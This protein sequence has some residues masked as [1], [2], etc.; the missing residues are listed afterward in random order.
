MIATVPG[1]VWRGA[2]ALLPAARQPGRLAE[3]AVKVA[4]LCREAD[5]NGIYRRLHSHWPN[6]DAIVIGGSEGRNVTWDAS[7]AAEL[8]DF[9]ERMQFF[10]TVTYLP[11]DILTKVDRA[12]MAVSLE[13]RVPM[14]DHRVVEAAWSLP[15]QLRRRGGVSKW[16]LRSI[17]ARHVP[18][19]L[20]DRPKKGFAVPL[21]A[22]LRGPLRE[23]AG[24]LLAADR[25][26]RQGYLEPAPIQRLWQDF[27]AGRPTFH[28]PLWGVLMFQSWLECYDGKR[29]A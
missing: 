3:R 7:L 26:G 2:A 12:S 25:L 13:A 20:L 28:D 19:A 14:L 29:P 11:D 5:A 1:P 18:E 24:D 15:R 22:W 27:L 8:P 6:P 16:L 9:V 17:A 23:W 10:D 4:A 21:A